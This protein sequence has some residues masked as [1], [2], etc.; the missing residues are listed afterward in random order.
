M[1]IFFESAKN[2]QVR[3]IRLTY[4]ILKLSMNFPSVISIFVPFSAI[5][6]LCASREHDAGSFSDTFI[7]F[8]KLINFDSVATC[9]RL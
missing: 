9:N 2:C 7:A 1:Y 3:I 8:L 6:Q 5:W 4:S